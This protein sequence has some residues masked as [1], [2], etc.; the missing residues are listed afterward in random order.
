[1][2]SLRDKM[3]MEAGRVWHWKAKAE[4]LDLFMSE[5]TLTEV[6]LLQL[7][8]RFQGRGLK[9]SPFTKP[10]EKKDGA[11]W[12]FWF[13][14]AGQA[15]GLRVQA[16]RLF[17][18]GNYESFRPKGTQTQ[19]LIQRAKDCHPVFV[20][21]ND[22]SAYKGGNPSC[23]CDAY[24]GPSYLGCTIASAHVVQKGH[25]NGATN[26]APVTIPWHCLLCQKHSI[27]NDSLPKT[28]AASINECLAL[29]KDVAKEVR[30]GCEVIECP[31]EFLPI[32]EGG[33]V[34]RGETEFRA[35]EWLEKYLRSR[36]L[37]GVA[38]I[39]AQG[40]D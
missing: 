37:A 38:L 22:S 10:Q 4:Q 34:P 33:V 6:I 3:R 40:R 27:K 26:I 23:R 13:I 18:T 7:A 17:P 20:F 15:F 30:D 19:T 35:P 28:V 29:A 9:V 11:D 39:V 21:Y 2:K 32:A 12:E 14:Q 16:K 8:S 5:E 31:K 1:M 24:R 36:K 25:S